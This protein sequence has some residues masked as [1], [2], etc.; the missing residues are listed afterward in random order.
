MN[1]LDQRDYNNKIEITGIKNANVNATTVV[2]TI[3]EKAG[4]TSGEI[5]HKEEKVTKVSENSAAKTSIVVHFQSRDERNKALGKIKTGKVYMKLGNSV[6]QDS[7]NVFINE[8]LCP[9]YK[10]LFFEANRVKKDKRLAFL[11]IK[12]G[13]ILLKKTEGSSVLRISC[14]EDLVLHINIRSVR[15]NWDLLCIKINNLLPVLDLLILTEVN[16]KEEEALVY[17]IRNYN[18]VNKCRILRNGGGVMVFYKSNLT[19]ENIN[20][21]LDEAE[22]LILKVRHLERKVEFILMAVYRSPKR[23][24]DRFLSDLS[25]WL[26][27]A[28]KR[29]DQIIMIGDINVCTL[30]KA[31]NNSRYLNILNNNTLLP[32]VTV[33]TREE[34][35]EGVPT[36]SCIDH[37]NYRLNRFYYTGKTAVITDKLADHYFIA[38]EVNTRDGNTNPNSRS[39]EPEY[40]QVIDKRKVQTEIEREDWES[41]KQ[42]ENPK[43]LCDQFT[44]KLNK[45]Y[46]SSKKVVQKKNKKKSLPWVNARVEEEIEIR[47]RLLKRWRNN[48]NNLLVY[49][50]YKK[51]RNITTNI[52]KKEKRIYLYKLFQDARGDMLRT[53]RIINELMDRKIREP[54]DEKLKLN[55][56]TD[57]LQVLANKFNSNFINQ[58]K[59]IKLKNNGPSL[60][61]RM[62]EYQLPNKMST[63]YLRLATEKDVR[64]ILRDM[65]KTGCCLDGLRNRD[66]IENPITF[67]PVVTNMINVMI[68]KADI[69]QKLKTSCITPLYKNK[70]PVDNLGAYRPVGTLPIIE[71]VLEKHIN[72]LTNKYLQDN[73][74]LPSFQHGFQGGKS[75]ITLLQETADQINTALDQRKCV[76]ILLLDLS[77]AFDTLDHGLLL[78]KLNEVGMN[79]P[80]FQNYFNSRTQVTRLG[81]HVSNEEDVNQGLIQGG[82]N[83]PTWYNLYTYDVQYVARRTTLRMFADDSCLISVHKE[84]ESAVKNVQADFIN[85]QKY[86]YNNNIYINEKKTEALALGYM[87]KR[88]DM[89]N[90]K[91]V[92][93]SRQCL[94]DKTYETNCQCTQVEYKQT[95]KYLGVTLDNE[96]KMHHHVD[97][98]SKKLRILQYKL[99][100]INADYFPMTVKRTIYFSLIDSILRYGVTLYNHAPQYAMNPLLKNQKKIKK[101]LFQQRNVPILMPHQLAEFVYLSMNF[102]DP[103]FRRLADQPYELRVQRFQRAQVYTTTYGDRRLDYI[104]P[105]LLNKYCQEFLQEKNKDKVKTKIREMIL[106]YG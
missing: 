17:Q 8:A 75:T 79:H 78:K 45:I 82:I 106:K 27:N 42:I 22:N 31:T 63:F 66:I 74:I 92:C 46:D 39:V 49:E 23:N 57:D 71:K 94:A 100:K 34:M 4:I 64:S 21:S 1:E 81:S 61:V 97:A 105:T 83:S 80:I 60:D 76:I 26:K 18:Q 11:W 14:G 28:I 51:Q 55:F 91:I 58:I 50:E 95:A 102:F 24:L 103:R 10:K 2:E 13:K 104:I 54:L 89:N 29:D 48:K 67:V 9:A 72:I 47:N 70:G 88:E 35:L 56:Q 68:K 41:L 99:C 73:N 53:W 87:C 85:L 12:D 62:I 32:S 59:E 44:T 38:L 16:L 37:V 36:I 69:P 40:I 52:I 6:N 96:F 20:Y 90:M 30:K 86:L 15:L 101:L 5:Q 7:S 33:P 93:H 77:F 19:I 3:F 43:D 65:K 84:V 25:F 98:I